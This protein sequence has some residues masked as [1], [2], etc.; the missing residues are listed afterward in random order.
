MFDDVVISMVAGRSAKGDGKRSIANVE[1]LL[2]LLP[3]L[4]EELLEV[5]GPGSTMIA[6]SIMPSGG[7]LSS[8]PL[9]NDCPLKSRRIPVV[10]PVPELPE[11]PEEA[12]PY[13]MPLS[14]P[15]K[16]SD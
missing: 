12:P 2:P 8:I 7:E 15:R 10:D 1:P 16:L 9:G 4:P 6:L 13:S 11:L 3:L 5:D 14:I